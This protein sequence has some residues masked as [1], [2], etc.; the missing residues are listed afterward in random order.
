MVNLLVAAA[1]SVLFYSFG[2]L[3]AELKIEICTNKTALS[4]VKPDLRRH[5]REATLVYQGRKIAACWAISPDGEI[6]LVDEEGDFGSLDPRGLVQ[7]KE[8]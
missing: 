8:V 3:Q 6:I 7:G 4:I 5:F 1:A 2:G